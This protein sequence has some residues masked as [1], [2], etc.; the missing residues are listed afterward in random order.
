LVKAPILVQPN[1]PKAFILDVDWSTKGVGV[2]MSQWE[3][4]NEI[5]VAYASY[6]SWSPIQKCFHPM[7]GKCYALIWG[8]MHFRQYLHHNHF[9][10]KTN[11]KPSEWLATMSDVYGR[12]GKWINMLQDN[13]LKI[14]HHLGSKHSNAKA[15]HKN[16]VRHANEN[17]DF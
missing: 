13:C 15:F 16:L 1:F 7:E 2:I 5:V 12:W 8:T 11:H 4:C 3:G 9:T 17:D 10:L 6:K 14:M